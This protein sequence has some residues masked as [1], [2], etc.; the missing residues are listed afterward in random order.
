MAISYYSSKYSL[1]LQQP[2]ENPSI[3][4][5]CGP[6]MLARRTKFP[7]VTEFNPAIALGMERERR[8]TNPKPACQRAHKLT[9]THQSPAFKMLYNPTF[10]NQEGERR[11]LRRSQPL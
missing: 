8:G 10:Q 11:V 6:A 1:S 3:R 9:S 4:R 7:P 5:S 2:K